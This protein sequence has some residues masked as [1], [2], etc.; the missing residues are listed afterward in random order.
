[1]CDRQPTFEP[2]LEASPVAVEGGLF[3]RRILRLKI[4]RN[5]LNPEQSVNHVGF[6]VEHLPRY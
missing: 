2:S 4:S 3:C 1:M 5:F 6:R